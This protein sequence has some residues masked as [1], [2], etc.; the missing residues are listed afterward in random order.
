MN[1]PR[2][3]L[4]VDPACPALTSGKITL[5]AKPARLVA[6]I[7]PQNHQVSPPGA[8]AV[9][10]IHSWRKRDRYG[11]P[12]VQLILEGEL[13]SGLVLGLGPYITGVYR[14]KDAQSMA[15]AEAF[16]QIDDL[17]DEFGSAVSE[18]TETLRQVVSALEEIDPMGSRLDIDT[19]EEIAAE[20]DASDHSVLIP[21]IKALAES[22]A[23]DY[24]SGAAKAA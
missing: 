1:F 13:M 6:M 12:E 2:V 19:A 15:R 16:E 20:L 21:E 23:A 9:K 24:A 4:F 7:S 10:A 18:A 8:S 17:L 3:H 22:F 11:M 14:F 5:W